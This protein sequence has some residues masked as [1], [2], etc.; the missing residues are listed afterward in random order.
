MFVQG[1]IICALVANAIASSIP[2][3]FLLPEPSGPFKIQREILELTDWSRKDINSTLPR[4]LMVSRFDP[5]PEKHCIRT[6][7]VPTFPPASAKLEDAILQAASGGHWVDGLLAASRIR[8]CADVKKGYQTDFHGDNHGFPILLFSPGGNTTRLVYSSIAQTISSAGY[9]VITID[10]PH[11]TDIVEF[12]N[13]DIIT[14]GKVTFSNPSVLPFWNDVRVQDTLFVLN[15][16]LETSPH[17]RIGMLGHSFG[18]SAVL[19]SMVKDG[20]ISAGIN[21]DGGLWGDAVNTG[22]GGRKKPQ[23]YLQWGAYTH[24]RRNDTSWETLWKAMERLHPH[25]W[26]KELGIPEGRHN[27]FSDFPAIIDAGGVRDVIDKAS[28]DVLVG[29]IPAV[30]SL[31]FIKAYVHDFFRF[32][33]FGKDEGLL[34][35]PSQKYPEVVFLD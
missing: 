35:G 34:R 2:S 17:A 25:A 7:D 31:E 1:T 10:H 24:N 4:R 21:L 9:T 12:L 13:G 18:G 26:K 22:L 6:E 16:A 33:L 8:V 20:R 28:I 30:R 23:P 27:T 3:S 5:I 14:G 32:S 15:Q 19:S 11:D 29:D